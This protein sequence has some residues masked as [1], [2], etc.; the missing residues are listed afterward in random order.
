MG[1]TKKKTTVSM[2][3]YLKL[4]EE[5][6]WLKKENAK[7]KSFLDATEST[8]DKLLEANNAWE[9]K[10]KKQDCISSGVMASTHPLDVAKEVSIKLSALNQIGMEVA[11][12]ALLADIKGRLKSGTSYV[13]AQAIETSVRNSQVISELGKSL[14]HEKNV[15][16]IMHDASHK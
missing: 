11:L 8:R 6:S 15:A 10:M 9:A 12:T 2:R 16:D 1:V 5:N 7:L 3:T 4:K 13:H 14:T